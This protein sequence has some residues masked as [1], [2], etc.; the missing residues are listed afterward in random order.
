VSKLSAQSVRYAAA[1]LS[2]IISEKGMK[3]FVD[4]DAAAEAVERGAAG[5]GFEHGGR[6]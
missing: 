1:K 3:L 2:A 4:I 6:A 5:E